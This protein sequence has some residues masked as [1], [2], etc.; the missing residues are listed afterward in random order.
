FGE[1]ASIFPVAW[2]IGDS[3]IIAGMLTTFNGL[4]EIVNISRATVVSGQI[5]SPILPKIITGDQQLT[6]EGSLV[7]IKDVN[8]IQSGT[9]KNSTN[10]DVADCS[11]TYITVRINV[12]VVNTLVN[13]SIPT[14][15]RDIVG[16]AGIFNTTPQLLPRSV[17]DISVVASNPC[18]IRGVCPP[19]ST[20]VPVNNIDRS[21][22]FDIAAWNAEWLGHPGFGPSNE[23]LQ[24]DNVKCILDKLQ[25]DVIVLSE[26][27]D[28]STLSTMIPTGYGYRCSTQFY[29]HFYDMPETP[30]DPAQKVCVVYN[31][32][33]VVPIESECKAI[34]TN[35][36]TYTVG[37]PNNSFWASG[38]LPYMFT[39]NVNI[40]GS[41]KKIRVV[42]LHAKAGSAITDYQRRLADVQALKK[43]L[44]DNYG[45]DNLIIAGDF[46]DDL[47]TSITVGQASSYANF[48]LDAANY[49]GVTK[50][51][52]DGK[53]RSTVSQSEMIDHMIISNELYAAYEDNTVGVATST[54]INFIKAYGTTTTDHYPVWARFDLSRSTSAVNTTTHID[55][56]Y[57]D[58]IPN[59]TT[60]HAFMTVRT[61][62]GKEVEISAYNVLGQQVYFS[63]NK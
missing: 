25:S 38:R 51:L 2:Q 36:A 32:A 15:T 48:I 34:L 61:D 57:A 62:S 40:N 10:Y 26:I 16:I 22:T 21:K 33:T 11:N 20:L 35:Q 53:K 31:K 7:K 59:P 9:F 52:S 45:K 58:F 42:G 29:S 47:D 17:T 4:K 41:S 14:N 54:N 8:F 12:D 27:C 37:S 60:G 50:E 24:Q 63:K 28:M 5:N 30:S 43:E 13:A 19:A 6:N 18:I 49:R 44:D 1:S 3:V 39:A 23:Q 56:L 46:N 55:K